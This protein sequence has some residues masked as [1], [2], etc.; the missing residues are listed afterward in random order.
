MTQGL[1]LGKER[2]ITRLMKPFEAH[3]NLQYENSD[4]KS[5][6]SGP[7][8]LYTVPRSKHV[9]GWPQASPA[10]HTTREEA[11]GLT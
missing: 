3:A 8:K 9:T 2:P 10:C 1:C 4:G 6:L 5:G 11:T 7:G